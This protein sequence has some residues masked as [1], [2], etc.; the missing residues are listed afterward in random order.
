VRTFLCLLLCS[1]A[2]SGAPPRNPLRVLRVSF[3]T[4]ARAA[5]APPLTV[6]DLTAKLVRTKR[7][8][9]HFEDLRTPRDP[10]GA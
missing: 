6:K 9:F 5:D 7:A 2:L 8:S 10:A 3:W 4:D 1:L